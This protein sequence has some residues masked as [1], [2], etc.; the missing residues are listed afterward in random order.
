MEGVYSYS[1]GFFEHKGKWLCLIQGRRKSRQMFI[2]DCVVKTSFGHQST[3]HTE[4]CT[5]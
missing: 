1:D 2:W 3:N 4:S 5:V